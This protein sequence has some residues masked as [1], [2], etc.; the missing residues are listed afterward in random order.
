MLESYKQNSVNQYSLEENKPGESFK[1]SKPEAVKQEASRHNLDWC[2]RNSLDLSHARLHD[3][4]NF[5]NQGLN[6]KDINNIQSIVFKSI[7]NTLSFKNPSKIIGDKEIKFNIQDIS[8]DVLLSALNSNYHIENLIPKKDDILSFV[9]G[10]TRDYITDLYKDLQVRRISFLHGPTGVGKTTLTKTLAYHLQIP[11][12]Q[13]TGTELKN[14]TQL[15]R[16]IQ[17]RDTETGQETVTVPSGLIKAA[18]IGALYQ[19]DEFNYLPGDVQLA[20]SQIVDDGEIIL[21]DGIRIPI[22]PNFAIIATGNIGYGGTNIVNEA[23]LRRAGGGKEIDYLPEDEEIE[24]VR[25]CFFEEIK[26]KNRV[27][28]KKLVPNI[29]DKEIEK[30]VKVLREMRDTIRQNYKESIT[31]LSKRTR[32]MNTQYAKNTIPGMEDL[33]SYHEQFSFRRIVDFVLRAF[34]ISIQESRET[35]NFSELFD[36]IFTLPP[37]ATEK[38]ERL[39]KKISLGKQINFN[40]IEAEDTKEDEPMNEIDVTKDIKYYKNLLIAQAEE[41]ISLAD[42]IKLLPFIDPGSNNNTEK[43]KKSSNIKKVNQVNDIVSNDLSLREVLPDIF[44]DFELVPN[45]KATVNDTSPEIYKENRITSYIEEVYDALLGIREKDGDTVYLNQTQ[46]V[47]ILSMK[48]ILVF[49]YKDQ[50][51]YALLGWKGIIKDAIYYQPNEKIFYIPNKDRIH[52][53]VQVYLPDPGGNIVLNPESGDITTVSKY[54]KTRDIDDT[55]NIDDRLREDSYIRVKTCTKKD[56]DSYLIKKLVTEKIQAALLHASDTPLKRNDRFDNTVR[57]ETKEIFSGLENGKS[58]SCPLSSSTAGRYLEYPTDD[59]KKILKSMEIDHL[60]CDNILLTGPTGTGKTSL[61]KTY[62]INKRLKY[63]S[64]QFHERVNE[65]EI[66]KQVQLSNG[67]IVE[68]A[69]PLLDAFKYGYVAE[70]REINLANPSMIPFINTLLDKNGYFYLN[71]K[72]ITRH[73]K[74]LPVATR[75]PF[76]EIYSGTK[77][78]PSSFINRFHEYTV[79]FPVK[80]QEQKMLLDVIKTENKE[81]HNNTPEKDLFN[82]IGILLN[83]VNTTR[84]KL[85]YENVSTELKLILQKQRWSTDML[86]DLMRYSKN[87]D[88]IIDTFLSKFILDAN[89]NKILIAHNIHYAIDLAELRKYKTI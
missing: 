9:S 34:L 21:P 37:Y 88:D 71:S 33:V 16:S 64:C 22:H 72:K 86:Q 65:G 14:Y 75:N 70:L 60:L 87:V 3:D 7:Q 15:T 27:F 50:L 66:L 67:K 56:R 20:I 35:I 77:P 79:D 41:N 23:V 63:V 82:V 73:P 55:S 36:Q 61:V 44:H 6:D 81:L 29:D 51:G 8:N 40:K 19:I 53:H 25:N 42:S 18:I 69:L 47:E 12:Y 59:I 10:T 89:E 46:N 74:F 11:L 78:M 62:A 43:T 85:Y 26:G 76:S 52:T 83:I 2:Q 45:K 58:L 1:P 24:S 30:I 38:V 32:Q 28:D 48:K 31:K 39:L 49:E 57:T 68:I 5:I 54:I 17:F 80:L 13:E 4:L 84:N